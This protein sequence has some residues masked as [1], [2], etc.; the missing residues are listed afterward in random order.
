MLDFYFGGRHKDDK[1]EMP[2]SS[3]K[4]YVVKIAVKYETKVLLVNMNIG[5]LCTKFIKLLLE[6]NSWPILFFFQANKI[7]SL[8]VDLSALFLLIIAYLH[9]EKKKKKS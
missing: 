8:S 6:I 9:R 2:D 1:Q 3:V 4:G 5:W 7:V